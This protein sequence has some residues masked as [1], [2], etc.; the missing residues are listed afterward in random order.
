MSFGSNMRFEVKDGGKGGIFWQ[1][2]KPKQKPRKFGYKNKQLRHAIRRPESEYI[3]EPID[4]PKPGKDFIKKNR[5]EVKKY[6]AD[7]DKENYSRNSFRSGATS[8][9]IKPGTVTLTQDQL[10]AL[11]A[12]VGKLKPGEGSGLRI[13]IDAE[14]NALHVDSPRDNMPNYSRPDAGDQASVQGEASIFDMAKSKHPGPEDYRDSSG[15]NSEDRSG[16]KEVRFNAGRNQERQEAPTAPSAPP[17]LVPWKHMTVAERKRLQWAREKA[18]EEEDQKK[19]KGPEYD[20]WG[21][22]GGGAPRQKQESDPETGGQFK[23]K[24]DEKLRTAVDNI[25]AKYDNFFNPPEKG[26]EKPRSK[27]ARQESNPDVCKEMEE[28][29]K[30]QKAIHDIE[31]KFGSILNSADN[32]QPSYPRAK[33]DIRQPDRHSDKD[34]GGIPGLDSSY[35]GDSKQRDG[36][37]P[38]GKKHL[39]DRGNARPSRQQ[40]RE[41]SRDRDTRERR[42]GG[43]TDP[44]KREPSRDEGKERERRSERRTREDDE[45]VERAQALAREELEQKVAAASGP[46]AMQSSLFMGKTEPDNTQFLS[47]KEQEK[48]RWLEELDLQREEKRLQK[49]REKQKQREGV[50]DTW[51]DRFVAEG[52]RQPAPPAQ[53]RSLQQQAPPPYASNNAYDDRPVGSSRMSEREDRGLPP[54]AMRTSMAIGDAAPN[55]DRIEQRQAEE[56]RLWLEDLNKQREEQRDARMQLKNKQRG[57][58]DTWA[59]RFS[60]QD[61]RTTAAAGL[62]PR[63]PPAP[64][65]PAPSAYSDHNR[66][67][68]APQPE[69]TNSMDESKTHLRGQNI[70]MDN[71]TRREQ[72]DKRRKHLEYQEAIKAQ[73]EEKAKIKRE[74][75]E[76]R[77][78]DE[79]EEE[80][81]FKTERDALQTQLVVEE[82]K[83]KQKEEARQRQ[84]EHLKSMMDAEQG[85][86]QEERMIKRLNTLQKAGHDVSGLKAHYEAITPRLHNAGVDPS[87][88][89]GL[90]PSPRDNYAYNSPRG[91]GSMYNAG[92][93]PGRHQERS[94]QPPVHEPYME[95]RTLTPS[96][97][98]QP[99]QPR[100]HLYDREF[101]TQTDDLGLS[102]GLRREFSEVDIEFRGQPSNRNNRDNNRNNRDNSR[103]NYNRNND[104]N[105]G[106]RQGRVSSAE[107]RR[108]PENP[109]GRPPPSKTT[110]Q[111]APAQHPRDGRP[112]KWNYQNPKLK[113]PVKQSEKD[114]F[115]E[116]KKQESEER[117]AKRERQMQYLVELNKEVIPTEKHKRPSQHP[118]SSE[119]NI[120]HVESDFADRREE[121]QQGVNGGGDLSH[122]SHSPPVNRTGGKYRP[123]ERNRSPPVP[124][125]KHRGANDSTRDYDTGRDAGQRSNRRSDRGFSPVID[126]RGNIK[127]PTRENDFIPFTRTTDIL[128]PSKAEDPVHLSREN[129]RIKQARK[130]YH[131]NLRPADFGN[132]LEVFEDKQRQPAPRNKDPIMNP[133]LVKDHPTA[134]QDQ[135]LQ[136]LSTL[137]QTLMQRQRELETCMSP[138]DLNLE[139]QL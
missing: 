27:A 77:W 37:A 85:R 88:V 93:G 132:P 122:R 109:R 98:R 78:K 44:R 130:H 84:V 135:I 67:N 18:A 52:S 47:K 62:S 4:K 41:K 134:R 34:S 83:T 39:D 15:Y 68:S 99:S 59:D 103:D 13:S 91:A 56:K 86:A 128:D 33:R 17:P 42:D 121:R 138:S 8:S 10:N 129:T 94:T 6:Q 43:K 26:K 63:N 28:V 70:H 104:D 102:G 40:D 110:K 120:L 81:K 20:P 35:A 50:D 36:R 106:P 123:S 48:R 29:E 69:V 116:R 1:K 72:E 61:P 118:S 111:R 58:E 105:R 125:V 23:S 31:A 117:R 137:K 131:E 32:D 92:G 87:S 12:T 95:N 57:L 76:R 9:E 90:Q 108:P 49:Q 97:N 5:E 112:A 139:K 119:H 115:Y 30:L 100:D 126:E 21:R 101:A 89:P 73:I 136:Q 82:N 80:K 38:K 25:E 71:V 65:Q 79:I 7:W 96:Q 19:R 66:I 114:P 55:L 53:S 24:G 60:K 74:E 133:S 54:A 16:G 107:R 3:E 75:R 113:A 64:Y 127:V 14:N 2:E 46:A 45:R 124:S 22:P 11:L 51:A